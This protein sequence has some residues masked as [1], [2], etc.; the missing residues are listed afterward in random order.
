MTSVPLVIVTCGAPF[1]A[2]LVVYI[3]R[4]AP[5]GALRVT[6]TSGAEHGVP[7]V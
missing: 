7:R 6:G 5:C 2:T 3:Q 4:G 1:G